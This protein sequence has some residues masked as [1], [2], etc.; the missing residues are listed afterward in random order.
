MT[1]DRAKAFKLPFGQNKG[2]TIDEVA[3]T[4]SGLLYLDWLLGWMERR[5]TFKNSLVFEAV[6][7]YLDHPAIRKELD[8]CAG[9]PRDA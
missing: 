8:A 7:A 3:S 1:F 6:G 4:D 5:G 2:K 9:G